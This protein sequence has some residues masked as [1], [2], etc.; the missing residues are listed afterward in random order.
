MNR[1]PQA[2]PRT[3]PETPPV[4]AHWDPGHPLA[5]RP[6]GPGDQAW[7]ERQAPIPSAPEPLGLRDRHRPQEKAP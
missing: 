4:S 3:G 6:C 7:I 5:N 1:L 2:P